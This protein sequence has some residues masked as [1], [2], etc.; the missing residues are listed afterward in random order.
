MGGTNSNPFREGGELLSE[1]TITHKT[2]DHF[3]T[4]LTH[5]R[6]QKEYLLR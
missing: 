3:L 6:T 5:K 2:P 1:Y 4:Y